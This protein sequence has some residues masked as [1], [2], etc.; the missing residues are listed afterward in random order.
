MAVPTAGA[1]ET[2]PGTSIQVGAGCQACESRPALRNPQDPFNYGASNTGSGNDY[3]AIQAALDAGGDLYFGHP[4]M[5]VI[6]TPNIYVPGGINIECAPGVTL[7]YTVVDNGGHDNALFWLTRSN[8]GVYG[9]NFQGAQTG[10]GPHLD[11][12]GH[13]DFGT[14]LIWV[15]NGSGYQIKC[16]TFDGAVGNAAVG[17]YPGPSLTGNSQLDF[18]YNSCS[19]DS[20]YCFVFDAQ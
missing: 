20:L 11:G 17:T 10:S 8:N 18:E 1:C 5:Y 16:N 15:G 7:D 4:G 3:S 2:I 9:C 6:S 14:Q 19:G 12:S 13:N